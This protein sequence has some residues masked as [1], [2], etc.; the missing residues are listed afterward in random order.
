METEAGRTSLTY[1]TAGGKMFVLVLVV[2]LAF[3]EV[4]LANALLYDIQR[5][6]PIAV[7]SG[8][9]WGARLWYDSTRR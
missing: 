8:F 6:L 1:L 7:G 3:R 4:L 2:T 9:G 5:S